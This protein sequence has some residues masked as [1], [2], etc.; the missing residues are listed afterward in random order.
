MIK[1]E[2]TD[3]L[4]KYLKLFPVVTLTGPRQSGKTT[5]L[6]N[7]LP[8]YDYYTLEDPEVRMLA[9]NDPR[10]FL[11]IKADG[12]IIDEAQRAPE[13]FSYIQGIVDQ[14]N[15][16]GMYVL[17]GSHNFLL[18]ETI[19]QTL[20]GRVAVL[21][22]LPLSLSELTDQAIVF[23]NY[24]DLLCNGFY[25]RLYDKNIAAADY[26]PFY[27]QTYIERDVRQV[28][29]I[30]DQSLFIRFLRL[31]A[32]RAGQILN[33]ASLAADAGISPITA[34]SWISVLEASY[35]IFL[36][37]PHY[38]N[39]NKRLVKN[40]KLYFTDTGLLSYLLGIDN[41]DQLS[42]HFAIGSVFENFI[43]TEFLKEFSNHNTRQNI[44]FWLDH[45]KKEIDL[46][47][48]QQELI[49]IEIKA[50]KTYNESFL[51][52]LNYWN[53]ISGNSDDNSF[54]IYGGDSDYKNSSIEIVSWRSLIALI[55]RLLPGA[56]YNH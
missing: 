24:E 4:L 39:F 13:L 12:M 19:S 3:T 29:N 8:N 1:R 48:E 40:P 6:K 54:I 32:G 49:P 53:K 22:L 33:L 50:G 26:Y 55:K 45:H 56:T 41:P 17:S 14:E 25:P 44:Y 16:E 18:L 34:R 35:I 38:K 27:L 28:R 36:L 42:V 21:K 46:L 31:L 23:K 20:A 52:Q 30:T 43:I 10:K 5:L 37:Q 51:A 15:R 7:I 9:L 11:E 47:I 2:M